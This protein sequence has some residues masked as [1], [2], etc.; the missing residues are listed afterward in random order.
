[1]KMPARNCCFSRKRPAQ[2]GVAVIVVLA[3]LAIILLYVGANARTLY[4]LG[5]ELKLVERQQLQRLAQPF[6]RTN[7]LPATNPRAPS[8]P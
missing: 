1:M 3:L 5:R 2:R 8:Q 4:Y 7:S 6:P